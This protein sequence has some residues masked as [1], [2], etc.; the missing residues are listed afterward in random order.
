MSTT[1]PR[2][3]ERAPE[4]G[5]PEARAAFRIETAV[6]DRYVP[7]GRGVLMGLAFLAAGVWYLWLGARGLWTR[8]QEPGISAIQLGAGVLAMMLMYGNFRSTGWGLWVTAA[9]LAGAGAWGVG[10]VA[11]DPVSKAGWGAVAVAA[12]CLHYLWTRR[13]LYGHNVVIRPF[14]TAW[15]ASPGVMEAVT[16]AAQRENVLV[17]LNNTI[18]DA[19]RIRDLVPDA[20]ESVAAAAGLRLERDLAE[21]SAWLYRLYLA[22]VMGDPA[23]QAEGHEEMAHL[24]ALLRLP[25][26]VVKDAHTKVGAELYRARVEAATADGVLDEGEKARLAGLQ[27]QLA[28]SEKDVSPIR[29]GAQATMLRGVYDEVSAGG[30]IDAAGQARLLAAIEQV[31]AGTVTPA[32]ARGIYQARL[33]HLLGDGDMSEAERASLDALQAALRLGGDEAQLIRTVQADSLARAAVERVTRDGKL[34]DAESR[35]LAELQERLGIDLR[36]DLRTRKSLDTARVMWQI[37]HGELPV[38]AASARLEPGEVCHAEVRASWKERIHV[39]RGT[40]RRTRT[41]VRHVE[42]FFG[43]YP[44]VDVETTETRDV[45]TARRTIDPARLL[46]TSRRIVWVGEARTRSWSYGELLDVSLDRNELLL[47]RD[48]GDNVRFMAEE[49]AKIFGMIVARAMRD[50]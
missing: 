4:P 40:A 12:L 22:G 32:L 6:G 18:A 9:L 26:T 35:E 11:D 1:A 39:E 43:P 15:P 50:A 36:A 45:R 3:V 17:A 20:L 21:D 31:G 37:A 24:A 19:G 13:A 27:A 47:H 44:D 16:G 49:D 28:L 29:D 14:Q 8:E 46:A 5:S 34:D 38:I 25:E 48:G 33:R 7:G 23:R 41:S 42:G 2:P 10:Q 30:T